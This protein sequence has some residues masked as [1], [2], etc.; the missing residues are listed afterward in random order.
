[1][2]L[3]EIMASLLRDMRGASSVEYG[4][5]LVMIVLAIMAALSGV[6]DETTGFWNDVSTK[7]AEAHKGSRS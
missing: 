7:S 3:R 1:M 4:M 6:A 2:K 5:L